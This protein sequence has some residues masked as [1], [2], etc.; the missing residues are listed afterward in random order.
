MYLHASSYICM[1]SGTFWYILEDSAYILELSACILEHSAFILEHSAFILEHSAF[2][3]EHSAYIL[4]HS[5]CILTNCPQTHTQTLGLVGLRLRSQKA[6]E[7]IVFLDSYSA[8]K[9]VF[10]VSPK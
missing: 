5:V 8:A 6:S 2:I 1:H 3:L 7:G 10:L 4:E 9:R